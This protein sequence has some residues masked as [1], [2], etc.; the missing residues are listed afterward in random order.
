[1]LPP[2]AKGRRVADDRPR[3]GYRTAGVRGP[4]PPER[5][6]HA[7]RQAWPLHVADLDTSRSASTAR[8][9]ITVTLSPEALAIRPQTGRMYG[10][11]EPRI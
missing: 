5:Q 2:K 10:D 8:A 6:R 1:M 9:H 3:P 11:S 7:A 4:V